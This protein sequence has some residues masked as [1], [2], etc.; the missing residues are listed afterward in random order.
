MQFVSQAFLDALAG[1][2]QVEVTADVL[3]GGV[4][5]YSGLPVTGGQVVFDRRQIASRRLECTITPTLPLDAYRAESALTGSRLGVYGHEVR[6]WWTVQ[7]VGE[8]VPLGRFRV[9]SLAGSLA[10]DGPVSLSGESREAYLRDA[11][12]LV[13][14]TLAGPSAR[15]L[16]G[17]LVREVLPQA[18]VVVTATRDA[19]VPDTPVE[20]GYWETITLLADSFAGRV[21][22]DGWGRVVIADLPT[23]DSPSVWRVTGGPGGVL[24]SADL[25]MDR[26]RVRNAWIVQGGSPS[27]DMPPMQAVVRDDDPS[28]PTCW[29]D[30]D[31]GAFGQSPEV[32]HISTL[33]SL[34]ECRTVGRARLALTCGA[35]QTVDLSAVPNAALEECDVI[36]IIPDPARAAASARRHI[37]DSGRIDLAA[38]GS[39][40]LSTRD[41]RQVGDQ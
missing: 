15:S 32:V 3:K 13:P 9:T 27:S 28:S 25:T 24:V 16:I 11:R 19:R 34:E 4:T 36:D 10:G 5:V 8:T 26:S 14:R 18:E 39:F 37:I 6:V 21:S 35:A 22:C 41:I 30:P 40:S 12:M 23:V 20:G 31:A 17:Q 7:P 1:S 38:G 2:H 29:G 33:T